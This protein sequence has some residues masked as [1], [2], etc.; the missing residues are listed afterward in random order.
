MTGPRRVRLASAMTLSALGA[1]LTVMPIL[2]AQPLATPEQRD[3]APSAA[4]STHGECTSP[5]GFGA[6]PLGRSG[7]LSWLAGEGSEHY[8]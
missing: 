6:S 8:A 7:R 5:V 2:H 3:L 4:D 1:A